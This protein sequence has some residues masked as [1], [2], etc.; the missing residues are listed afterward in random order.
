MTLL[1]IKIWGGALGFAEIWGEISP[2]NPP[3]WGGK[4]NTGHLRI[5]LQILDEATQTWFTLVT[6]VRAYE[7]EMLFRVAGPAPIRS[8]ARAE[9]ISI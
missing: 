3:I 4:E 2:Q 9:Y 8:L 1:L 7:I 6:V 5:S